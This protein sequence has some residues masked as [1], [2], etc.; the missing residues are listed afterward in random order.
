MIRRMRDRTLIAVVDDDASVC[1]AL[2]RLLRSARMD[3]EAYVSAS[4]FLETGEAHN[5]DCLVLDVQMPGM[6]GPEL[7][8]ELA[9][10]GRRIPIVFITAY[11]AIEAHRGSGHAAC[12]QKPFSDR[13]LL[14]AIAAA[15]EWSDP[16]GD[17]PGQ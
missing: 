3:A 9:A 1:R 15:L 10:R 8:E 7:R 11:E 5:P 13:A 6:T 16:S 14:D 17:E 4:E 12:L 2:S